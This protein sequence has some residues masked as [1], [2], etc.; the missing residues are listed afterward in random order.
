MAS[1][2][3]SAIVS[4]TIEHRAPELFDNVSENVALLKRLKGKGK[5]KTF[6]GGRE[7]LEPLAYQENG[8]YKRYSGYETLDIS[9]SDVIS[10][11]AYQIRQSALA[12]SISGL[13]MLQNSG[14]EAFL[15]LLDSR[16]EVAENTFMNNLSA[17]IYSDGTATGQING[18]A[19]IVDPTPAVGTVGGINAATWSF[20][21][22]YAYDA[23]TDGGA[24]A[25]SAN[26][27][28]YMNEVFVNVC[29]GNDKPDLIVA[30]NNYWTLYLESLQAIQRIQSD[31]M[32]QA[33]FSSLKYMNSDVILDGGYGGDAQTNHMYF[34][35]TKYLRF[36]SHRDRLMKVIGGD[37]LPVNQD[38]LVKIIAWAGN[39]TCSNRFLQGLLKD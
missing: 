14:K 39:L 5:L 23:T 37:R 38:A 17:D 35:N 8:T 25:T 12:V 32:G 13:E 28:Q 2:N 20:W 27:Q 24:A 10:A 22:N 6:S 15:D 9:P 1:P 26:I 19:A 33:G 11:A 31:D 34:L 18:L 21:R 4:T 30:D 3:Y 29:R 36:C 16:L 7:L